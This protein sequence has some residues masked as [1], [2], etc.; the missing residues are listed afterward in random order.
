MNVLRMVKLF[1]WE[2][3]MDERITSKRED[4]MVWIKYR[5]LLDLLNG[6]VKYGTLFLIFRFVLT[7][8]ISFIIPVITMITTYAV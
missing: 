8:N 6:V 7:C 3:R 5:Q 1:G 4:E 2:T